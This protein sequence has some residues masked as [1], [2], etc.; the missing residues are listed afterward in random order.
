MGAVLRV[1][2]EGFGS[3]G[4]RW[5][6]LVCSICQ[7]APVPH[8]Q[9]SRPG[10]GQSGGSQIYKGEQSFFKSFVP[11]QIGKKERPGRERYVGEESN[12]LR[13][14]YQ[15][16]LAIAWPVGGWGKE[17]LVIGLHMK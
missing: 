1:G 6:F 16:F 13:S 15:G 10:Q 17:E 7:P 3:G 8:P 14:L 9:A 11:K 5:I 12:L 4:V 2:T